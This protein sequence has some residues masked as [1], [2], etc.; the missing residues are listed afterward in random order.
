MTKTK[1]VLTD[2]PSGEIDRLNNVHEIDLDTSSFKNGSNV[3]VMG[4]YHGGAY[5]GGI[6]VNENQI[7]IVLAAMAWLMNTNSKIDV[8]VWTNSSDVDALFYGIE[9]AVSK[10]ALELPK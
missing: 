3:A 6:S 7:P 4:V 5:F 8:L 9:S 10:K 2:I 1:K